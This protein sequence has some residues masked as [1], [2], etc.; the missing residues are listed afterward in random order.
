M[1]SKKLLQ[2]LLAAGISVF[3]ALSCMAA[4]ACNNGNDNAG[5]QS[6]TGDQ[7]D[8]DTTPGGGNDNTDP[9]NPDTD[10]PETPGTGDN[11]DGDGDEERTSTP[12]PAGNKIYL[13]GDSTVCSFN[14]N[15]YMP[16]YGYGTQIA[17]YFNVTSDQVVN[18]ALSGRSSLSFLTEPNYTTLKNSIGEGDYLIIGFGHN[19]EK[20]DD[21]A[22][23]T[24]PQKSYTDSSTTGGPSFQ[25]TLYENYVKLAKDAGATPILCT[26]IVRYDSAGAYTGSKVHS[27]D[28]G[29]YAA[30]I[31]T[32]GEATD[33]TV[34]DLTTLTRTLYMQDN[35]EAQYFHAHTTYEGTKP[36]ETPSGRDD[37][38]INKY[39]A[40]MVAYMFA[41]AILD[42][43]STLAAHV[44]EDIA[45][46]TDKSI[47][48]NEDYILVA[49]TAPDLEN[50][51]AIATINGTNSQTQQAY[52]TTWYKSVFG[53][54]GGDNVSKFSISYANDTF[55]VGNSGGQ[56]KFASKSDGLGAAFMRV[57][58]DDN[59]TITVNAK[60]TAA[61]A[62]ANNQSG[63]GIM[64][65]DD[66]L[67]DTYSATLRSNFVVAGMLYDG[68]TIFSRSSEKLTKGS[69]SITPAIGTT[70]TMTITRLGQVVTVTVKDGD[71]EYKQTYTDFDFTAV[72][73][74]YMY[75]C[76][77]A[78]RDLTVEYCNVTFSYDGVA[79]GA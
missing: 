21:A 16:R 59:F 43:D 65:R 36:D 72:D 32:L 46:P 27:T 10:T 48:I 49:Y 17:E 11:D 2:K 29:D 79:Q 19:D 50:M 18:L 3:V 75:I 5:D 51:T 24:D 1:T 71:N 40:Q 52:A 37:T 33:T 6:N 8:D 28:K 15:Y 23:Y 9:E 67:I 70:Y 74:N 61:G 47:A 31:K 26:P 64:L 14:D 57:S 34:I 55:T 38:H 41:D 20:D 25:Y 4:A 69:K 78:N 66:M 13:V 62:K 56:G 60:I 77:F 42:T 39:G 63:F 68:T 22:R 7:T 54:I 44:N 45:A 58:K 76:L 73:N 53:D 30:A 12:L 35:E